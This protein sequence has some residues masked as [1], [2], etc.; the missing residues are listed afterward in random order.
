[1]CPPRRL[2]TAAA[3][4][5]LLSSVFSGCQ[6]QQLRDENAPLPVVLTTDCGADIDDQWALVHLLLSPELDLRAVI[7]THAASVKY[8]SAASAQCATGVLAHVPPASAAR[9]PAV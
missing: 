1:M 2:C 3:T 5:V 6:T 8:S 9:R 7:T 4:L